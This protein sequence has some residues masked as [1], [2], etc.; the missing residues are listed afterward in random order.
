[1]LRLDPAHPP[2]WRSSAALQF[3][4]EPVAIV[5]EPA[6]WQLR[7]VRELE[8]GI[9]EGS[10]DVVAEAFGAPEGAARGFV[11]S[12]ARALAAPHEP[13]RPRVIVQ[14]PSGG[15]AEA[16][17]VAAA[18]ASAG[19]DVA[20]E[21]WWGHSEAPRDST[22]AVV[23]LAHH[24]VEPRRAAPLVGRDVP[25]IPIVLA[26]SR[27]EVGPVVHPG[28]T[29]CLA[30]LAAHRRDHDEAWPRVAAQLVGRPPHTVPRAAVLEAGLVAA[31][32]LSA[33][34]PSLDGQTSHSLTLRVDS[35]QRTTRTHRMHEE[36]RC[37]SLAETATETAR[38]TPT[39]TTATGYARPA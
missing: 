35:L 24:L 6:P 32:L 1:M 10:L 26:G 34:A 36:C 13:G 22:V 11:R 20:H 8:R 37:R 4:A 19:F 15:E 3:G 23:L 27:I 29:P 7:L 33:E 28:R 38:D 2:L 30:C 25:H 9:P 17:A 31:H 18:L 21:T 16:D 5:A 39:P 12:I 14:A